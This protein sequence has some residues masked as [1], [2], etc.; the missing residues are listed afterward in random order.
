MGTIFLVLSVFVLGT[1]AVFG[2]YL[3]VTK[4][5][6]YLLQRKLNS[7]LGEVTAIEDKTELGGAELVKGQHEGPLP[8]FDRMTAGTARGAAFGTWLEQSGMR[9]S[10]SG[11]LLISFGCG[12]LA[13]LLVTTALRMT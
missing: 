8:A 2:A 13:G 4:L 12:T 3:A 1:G 10:V 7:R 11:V 5:P 6:G 9:V